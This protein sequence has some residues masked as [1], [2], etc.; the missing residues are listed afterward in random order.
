MLLGA[1]V[2]VTWIV[3]WQLMRTVGLMPASSAAVSTTALKLDPVWR[4][5]VAMLIELWPASVSLP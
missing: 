5:V 1:H 3:A 4:G 2:G